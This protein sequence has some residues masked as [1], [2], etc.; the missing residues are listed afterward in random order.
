[1][2]TDLSSGH[3]SASDR[4]KDIK[5]RSFEMSFIIDQITPP[6]RR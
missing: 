2:E 6:D 4:Y 5:H 1:L 3:F